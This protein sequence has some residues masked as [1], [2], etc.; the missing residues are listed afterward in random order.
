MITLWCGFLIQGCLWTVLA[1]TFIYFT[2]LH[3]VKKVITPPHPHAG[4]PTVPQN[5]L[6][7][8][9]P[10][11]WKRIW[12]SVCTWTG[13]GGCC[14]HS[15]PRAYQ[16]AGS[17]S[18]LPPKGSL[19][20]TCEFS[21]S[22]SCATSVRRSGLLAGSWRSDLSGV[23]VST[24]LLEK[25]SNISGDTEHPWLPSGGA[26]LEGWWWAPCLW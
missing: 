8:S 15:G 13:E 7:A 1:A 11:P 14:C 23:M 20:W 18:P 25:Q 24:R 3:E 19:A 10:S 17:F 16:C 2:F 12:I 6:W 22:G 5:L 9:C 4:L 26:R 21:L